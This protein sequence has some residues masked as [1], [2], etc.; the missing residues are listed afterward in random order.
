MAVIAPFT[1]ATH[2]ILVAAGKL[3][4]VI[5]GGKFRLTVSLVSIGYWP[6]AV[7]RDVPH[8]F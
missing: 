8:E 5:F 6:L 4:G 7:G 1:L 2:I 3:L